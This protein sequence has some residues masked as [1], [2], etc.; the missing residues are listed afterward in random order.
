VALLQ[1]EFYGKPAKVIFHES[2]Q[3]M[4]QFRD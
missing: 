1:N 3:D 2:L 4:T